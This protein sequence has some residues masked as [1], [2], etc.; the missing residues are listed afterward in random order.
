MRGIAICRFLISGVQN[1][2]LPVCPLENCPSRM[3]GIS[4]LKT[5]F[6]RKFNKA[7]YKN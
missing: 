4:Y 5:Y 1:E 2:T 6:H 3:T 7:A